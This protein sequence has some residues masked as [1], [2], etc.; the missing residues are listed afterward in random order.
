MRITQRA[1]VLT[2]MQGL[3]RNLDTLGKLQQQLTSGKQISAPSVSPTGTNRAMQ[4]RSDQT[5]VEQQ[6]RNLSD[7][8]SWLDQTASTLQTIVTQTRKV[9]ELTVQGLNTGALSGP[10]QEALAT[11]A[12]SLRE[13]IIALANTQTQGR[14]LFGGVTSGGKAYDPSGAWVGDDSA[15]VMRRVSDTENIRIDITGLEAFGAG[16]D[17]L[18]AV[19][20]SI[21]SEL[22]GDPAVLTAD[23]AKLDVAMD[24]M[25]A[26][27]ANIGSRGTRVEGLAQINSDRALA[28]KSQLSVTE[29]IDLPETIMRVQMAKTGYE[30]A[31]AAT[32]KSISPTLLDYLR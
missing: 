15:P 29:D 26:G 5:A 31:L 30:A 8:Q 28:L 32:A 2:S 11:E 13:G 22:E 21:A 4:I 25:L 10:S 6:A 3:N 27:L 1:V 24:R 7:A 14:P 18:F 17:D 16:P 19:L 23:L 9:R 20:G 12:A